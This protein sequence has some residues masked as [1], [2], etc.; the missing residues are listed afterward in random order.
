[1]NISNLIKKLKKKELQER[2]P[3][4]AEYLNNGINP[5]EKKRYAEFYNLSLEALKRNK[6]VTRAE[7]ELLR[8][9]YLSGGIYS[10]N[11]VHQI[12]C[13]AVGED[14]RTPSIEM[15]ENKIKGKQ[16]I[17]KPKEEKIGKT[18]FQ[19]TG[20]GENNRRKNNHLP[21]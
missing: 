1:M 13:V 17:K 16:R 2:V 7:E 4:I 8:L 3:I 11:L 19:K 6:S 5:I 18:F 9:G 10:Y 12:A 20:I 14:I 15:K 21:Y